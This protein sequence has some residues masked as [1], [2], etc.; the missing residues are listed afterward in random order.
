[1]YDD[2]LSFSAVLCPTAQFY[3]DM[4]HEDCVTYRVGDY[5]AANKGAE[6]SSPIEPV[7]LSEAKDLCLWYSAQE[8]LRFAQ[9]DR[10]DDSDRE[11]K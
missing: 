4:G 8:I 2:T 11:D 6:L 5:F 1:M 9:D 3:C 10:F 7:I